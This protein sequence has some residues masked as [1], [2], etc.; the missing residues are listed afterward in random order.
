MEDPLI[1]A[2]EVLPGA[3]L[4]GTP[5]PSATPTL[6]LPPAESQTT[7]PAVTLTPTYESVGIVVQYT[8]DIDADNTASVEWR[9]A[10]TSAWH[11]GHPLVVDRREAI[12]M[13]GSVLS[14]NP[15]KDQYRGSLMGL[16][17]G[18]E[19]EVRV[20][21]ADPDGLRGGP[22]DGT[23]VERVATWTDT[24]QIPDVGPSVR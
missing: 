1:N 16:K 19:Y 8:G 14:L 9:E 4:S 13:R 6:S 22:G 5:V 15:Y 18:T 12:T 17:A 10:G 23:L 2:I 20:T 11:H 7:L 21:I 3:P 24:S